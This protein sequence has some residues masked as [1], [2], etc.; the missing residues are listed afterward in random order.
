[1]TAAPGAT[2]VTRPVEM[3]MVAIAGLAL[4]HEPPGERSVREV[5]APMH[6]AATPVI[7][8]GSGITDTVPMTW[9]PVGNV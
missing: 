4:A 1:M 5:V 7:A 9:Q 3:P 8:A 2:L 6:I